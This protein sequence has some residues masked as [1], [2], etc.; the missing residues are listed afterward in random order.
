[1][2]VSPSV[3]LGESGL[4]GP[5]NLHR[6]GDV[7]DDHLVSRLVGLFAVAFGSIP[8]SSPP[9][10]SQFSKSQLPPGEPGK[11][12]L[13]F[14]K[15]RDWT[16]SVARLHCDSSDSHPR[17]SAG[18]TKSRLTTFRPRIRGWVSTC[19]PAPEPASTL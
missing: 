9:L 5:A 2:P 19:N 11:L 16:R 10:G 6:R 1:M 17:A 7:S 14:R 12:L 4:T 8:P 3:Q 15:N 18:Y 13:V